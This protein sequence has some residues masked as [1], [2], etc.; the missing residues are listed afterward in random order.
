[1]T[2]ITCT[3]DLRRLARRRIPRAIF[4]YVDGGSYDELT[5]TANRRDLDAIRLR[6][7]VMVD[8]SG[9]NMACTIAGSSAAMPVV[10]APT[11]LAGLVHARGEVL[12][13]QAA[14][15][16]GVPFCLSTVSICSIEEVAAAAVRPFWFQL[17]LMKDRDFV[18]SLIARAAAA[19]CAALVVTVD[20]PVTG[21]RHR[22]L[23]NGL[24]VPPRL[25]LG[26]LLDMAT[27]PAWGLR[28]LAGRRFTFGNLDGHIPPQPRGTSMAH[29]IMGQFQPAIGWD[30]IAWIKSLWPG[31]LVIKGVTDPDDARAAIDAGADAI[32]VSN[33]GGRQLDSGP[34]SIAALPGVVAAVKG[35]ADIL[36]DGGVRSG[37]DVLKALALG[38]S[39]TMVG[40][41]FLYGLG[42]DGRR[43]VD[44]VLRV[45]RQE[46][47]ISMALTGTRDVAE[48]GA[49]TLFTD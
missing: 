13:A 31:K 28:L 23:K 6:Q 35:R 27:K 17:Y 44:A 1:M 38:A 34:S 46:L 24:S 4:D 47:D 19:Q 3:D 39:A 41:A 25:T 15:A 5:L 11:G 32:V 9:R 14:D 22:D 30:D 37:Q 10:I 36:F 29:W 48:A 33:H 12:A 21:Q 7:R 8:V 20:L 45:I 18:A 43:G 40:R 16:A 26:N 2:V 42:A 49:R